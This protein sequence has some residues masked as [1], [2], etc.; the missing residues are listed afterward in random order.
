M[1]KPYHRLSPDERAALRADLKRLMLSAL[2]HRSIL[3]LLAVRYNLEESGVYLNMRTLLKSM[4]FRNRLEF[5][6]ANI[7]TELK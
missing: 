4:G 5:M 6:S 7:P 2:K 3:R 1:R